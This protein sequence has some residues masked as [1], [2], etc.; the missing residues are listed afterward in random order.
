MSGTDAAPTGISISAGMVGAPGGRESH[1]IGCDILPRR[2][3]AAL[4]RS[5]QRV[6]ARW[7]SASEGSDRDMHD[8]SPVAERPL[9]REERGLRFAVGVIGLLSAGFIAT[10]V[11]TAVTYHSRY[12]FVANSLAKDALFVALAIIGVGDI[13]RYAYTAVLLVIGHLVLVVGL[14]PRAHLRRCL[15]GRR[16]L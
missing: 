5:A 6:G 8:D 14:D 12:P 7:R 3:G 13:R 4:V 15:E 9:T 1:A 16:D 10:Y 11:V 2:V